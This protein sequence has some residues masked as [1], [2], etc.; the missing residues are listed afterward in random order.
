VD[1][2]DTALDAGD[3]PVSP[4]KAKELTL[5]FSQGGFHMRADRRA[6]PAARQAVGTLVAL[7]DGNPDKALVMK[8]IGQLAAA[9]FA[10][11]QMRENGEVEARFTSGETYLFADK[12]ILRLA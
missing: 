11:L 10:E 7:A 9:G 3:T 6:G 4:A 8:Y 5:M 1:I 12:T 2:A